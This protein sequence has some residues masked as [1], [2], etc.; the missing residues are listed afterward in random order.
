VI[1]RR[2]LLALCA[3]LLPAWAA[4][5]TLTVSAAAS[6]ADALREAGRRFEAAHPGV[7][8]RWNFAA[9]GVLVQQILQGAPVDVFLSA[10][11]V[12]MDRGVAG[13]A[14][15]AATR[16]DIARNTLVLVAPA[17]STAPRE[18]ADLAQA[19]VRRIAIGKPATV[20]AGRYTQQVL[21]AA[22]LWG[23]LQPKLVPADNVRQVLDVVSRGEVEAGFVYRTDAA[24]Q[25]ERLRIVLTASGHEPI[26]LPGA[27]VA[28]TRQ[29][30]LARAF[31]AH[32]GTAESRAV[33][34]SF[35]FGAP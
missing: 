15:D 17:G 24:L 10:D 4:A 23:P 2:T 3:V 30:A 28:G 35:G 18:L 13:R 27:V 9:S 26:T 32:L 1:L 8:L 20:P 33:F 12:T 11:Q 34:A 19:G 29:P 21:E 6:L 7:T 5:Q 14:I 25:R 16:R 22:R 31:L